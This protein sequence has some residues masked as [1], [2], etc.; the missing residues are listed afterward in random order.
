MYAQILVVDEIHELAGRVTDAVVTVL[1][2]LAAELT[3][4]ELRSA[5]GALVA[6]ARHQLAHAPVDPEPLVWAVLHGGSVPPAERSPAPA[7][8]VASADPIAAPVLA[9]LPAP[10]LPAPPAPPAPPAYWPA[11]PAISDEL[12][13]RYT[14]SLPKAQDEQL[15]DFLV[16]APAPGTAHEPVPVR[17][18]AAGTVLDIVHGGRF[19]GRSRQLRKKSNRH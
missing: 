11:V 4:P 1:E 3:D 14:A 6:R 12:F 9:D 13:A 17:T 2:D 5:M 16:G 10:A 18:E 15:S 8:P 7:A 19:T